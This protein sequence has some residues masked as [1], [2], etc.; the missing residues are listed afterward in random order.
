MKPSPYTAQGD[1]RSAIN[2]LESIA[3]G[4]GAVTVEDVEDL[5]VRDRQ[6]YTP[7]IIHNIFAAKTLYE[8]RK[9][10]NQAYVDH[11]ELFDWIYENLP[12]ILEDKRDLVEGLEALISR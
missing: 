6:E 8:A 10:I 11:E 2:D 12:L 7:A 3:S 9:A 5:G 4:K 1:L